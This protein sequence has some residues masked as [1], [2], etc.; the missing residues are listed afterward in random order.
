MNKSF[1]GLGNQRGEGRFHARPAGRP[2]HTAASQ[3][4]LGET[5]QQ[6]IKPAVSPGIF[7]FEMIIIVSTNSSEWKCVAS[8]WFTAAALKTKVDYFLGLIQY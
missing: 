1:A 2:L 8:H 3:H 5:S 6:I 7:F 4:D